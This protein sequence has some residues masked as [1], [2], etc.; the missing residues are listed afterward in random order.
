[1]LFDSHT[2]I[3]FPAYD[4][5]RDDVISRAKGAGVK[6]ITVGTQYQTSRAGV[7]LAEK[8]PEDIWATVGFHPNH[9]TDPAHKPG[10]EKWHH[11]RN[12]QLES[13]PEKFE[14]RYNSDLANG[15]GNF[16]SRVL[17]LGNGLGE[18]KIDLIKDIEVGVADK[19]LAL[20]KL[21]EEKVAEFKFHDAL[22]YVWELIAFGDAYVNAKKPWD[23]SVSVEEKRL[24]ILNSAVIL[25]NVAALI[26]P[27][28]P[29]T[30][31]KIT[32][33]IEWTGHDILKINKIANLF[34]RI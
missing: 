8:Y 2:H 32:K 25:D 18:I 29:E 4:A 11:D 14:D 15:L 31:S 26:Y 1:M 28:L 13:V 22:A 9:A 7:L 24:A 17:T 19:I 16:V 12:E 23:K 21:V 30:S 34:P 5:D 20:R 6:M 10:G 3:Q 27:F 33:A